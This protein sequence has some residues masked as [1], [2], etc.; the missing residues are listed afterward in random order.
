MP[1]RRF[2]E[3]F[4]RRDQSAFPELGQP[5]VG[6]DI[7]ELV[8]E[9]DHRYR[10]ARR[11]ERPRPGRPMPASRRSTARRRWRSARSRPARRSPT[12]SGRARRRRLLPAAA[13]RGRSA[14]AR[15][16]RRPEPPRSTWKSSPESIA[17][18]PVL[19]AL[20]TVPILTTMAL[21]SPTFADHL[22]QVAHR[23][24]RSP[25][26][27]RRWR[28][29]PRRRTSAARTRSLGSR[30]SAAPTSSP[31]GHHVGPGRRLRG[32]PGST[33]R[34]AR[35]R[36]PAVAGRRRTILMTMKGDAC[37]RTSG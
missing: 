11:L 16:C 24:C 32:R 8:D 20:V 35:R 13:G 37:E 19:R 31:A 21:L 9:G 17:T 33:A 26:G 23:S 30:R 36:P 28:R 22:T 4:R 3:S 6:G 12:G 29:C 5:G 14:H 25:A 10:R 27:R 34:G 18:R 7:L 1:S 2:I 15:R